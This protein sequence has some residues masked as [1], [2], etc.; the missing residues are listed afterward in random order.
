MRFLNKDLC[1]ILFEYGLNSWP[2]G[3]VG[4]PKKNYIDIVGFSDEI[5]LVK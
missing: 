5:L 3:R 2:M 4:K 1:I